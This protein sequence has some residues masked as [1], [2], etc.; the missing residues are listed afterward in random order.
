[1]EMKKPYLR[2]EIAKSVSFGSVSSV[3]QSSVVSDIPQI[4]ST[5][6]TV[7]DVDFTGAAFNHDWG[8]E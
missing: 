5:G 6:Q 4:E 3:L 7:T 2:P 1:M 8:V